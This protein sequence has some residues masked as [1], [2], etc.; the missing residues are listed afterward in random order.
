MNQE[1]VHQLLTQL[2]EV[3]SALQTLPQHL[4]HRIDA[5]NNQSLQEGLKTLQEFNDNLAAFEKAT[6]AISQQ[7]QGFFENLSPP[8]PK[9]PTPAKTHPKTAPPKAPSNASSVKK[10]LRDLKRFPCITLDDSFTHKKPYGFQL[11][12]QAWSQLQSWREVYLSFL[13][14]LIQHDPAAFARLPKDLDYISK[15]GNPMFGYDNTSFRDGKAL[16]NGLFVE[17]NLSAE[18]IRSHMKSLLKTFEIPEE[19][20]RLYLRVT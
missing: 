10:T 7:L 13:N 8:Q 18:S 17:A 5:A 20:C 14:A 6:G 4:L 15:S 11:Q 16:A 3:Q 1:T 2:A 9:K 19:E 12:D